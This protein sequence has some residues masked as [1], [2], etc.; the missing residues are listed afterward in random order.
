MEVVL[1]GTGTPN[2]A[3]LASKN[4]AEQAQDNGVRS[5]DIL[6]KRP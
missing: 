2:A 3:P 4:A 6:V 5:F 1:L